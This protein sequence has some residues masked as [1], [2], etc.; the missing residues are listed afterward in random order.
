[1][2]N[3]IFIK[4]MEILI[5]LIVFFLVFSTIKSEGAD[6]NDGVFEEV[7]VGLVVDLGSIEGKILETSFSLAL[8]DFYSVNDG[9]RNRVSVLVR[10]SQGD[11]LLALAAGEFLHLFLLCFVSN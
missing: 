11:P 6:R 5:S 10:D 8:S 7:R 4:S 3:T 1:M 2:K 9:Y